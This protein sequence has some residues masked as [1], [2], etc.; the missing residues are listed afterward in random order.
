MKNMLTP[1]A[2][3]VLIPVGLTTAAAATDA[4]IQR[5]IHG[6]GMTTLIISNKEIDDIMK[7]AKYLQ[8]SGLL[9][10][11]FSKIIKNEAEEQK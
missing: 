7:I 6:L 8:E 1:L 4:A 9:I 2:K 11:D 5:N 10:K 3:S